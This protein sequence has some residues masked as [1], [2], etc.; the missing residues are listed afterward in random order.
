MFHPSLED[1][2]AEELLCTSAKAKHKKKEKIAWKKNRKISKSLPQPTLISLK[3]IN[4]E[5][6]ELSAF[7]LFQLYFNKD[8]NNLAKTEF[9]RY[10]KQKLNHKFYLLQSDLDAFVG[11]VLLSGCH[12]LPQEHLYWCNDEDVGINIVKKKISQNR[13][14]EIK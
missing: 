1:T 13:F 14:Q 11:T 7:Q 8:V 10:A 2:H 6:L 4:P 5:L 12:T 9:K 3:E